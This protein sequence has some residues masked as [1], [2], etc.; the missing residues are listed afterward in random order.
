MEQRQ[1]REKE[2][3]VSY[4]IDKEISKIWVRETETDRT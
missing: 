3:D 2:I 4:H 1:R